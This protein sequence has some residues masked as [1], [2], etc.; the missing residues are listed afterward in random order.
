[1]SGSQSTRRVTSLTLTAALALFLF[2]PTRCQVT[3]EGKPK[4]KTENSLAP[5]VA[6]W[7]YMLDDLAREARTLT[8]E[9]KRGVVSEDRHE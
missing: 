5:D 6:R 3:P 2:E 4:T 9:E 1:M 7:Q 8:Q